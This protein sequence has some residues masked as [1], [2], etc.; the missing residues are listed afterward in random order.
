MTPRRTPA[1]ALVEALAQRTPVDDSIVA[2]LPEIADSDAWLL[3]A[4]IGKALPTEVEVRRAARLARR[5]G[6]A[7]LIEFC[8]REARRGGRTARRVRLLRDAVVVDVRHTA[9]TELA[10]GIQ[11]VARETVRR[12]HHDHDVTLA[13]WTEDSMSLRVLQPAEE[14][15]ALHGVFPEHRTSAAIDRDV[16]VPVGGVFLL[17]ELAAESWRTDRIAALARHSGAVS[18]VIGFD[19]V[20]LTTA[21]TVGAGMSGAFARNLNAVAEMD[22]VVAISEAAAAEYRGWRAML[23]SKGLVGPDIHAVLLAADRRDSTAEEIAYFR[24]LVGNEEDEPIVFVVGSHEPRKNHGAVIH[25]AELLWNEGERF[26]LVFVGGNAWNSHD[27]T[28]RVKRLQAE[29]RPVVTLH[30]IAEPVL[31]AG[32]HVARFTVFPSLNEGYGLPIAESAACG[33]PVVTSAYGSMREVG[34]GNGALLVDPHDD[35]SVAEGIRTLLRD[36]ATFARLSAEAEAYRP[37]SW[38]EYAAL[39]WQYLVHGGR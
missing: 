29:G 2:A 14:A 4:A 10:T 22:R 15:T 20:P 37:R 30:S 16:I 6:V 12:W 11:R 33:T 36:D 23:P 19:C 26:R 9:E 38:D 21:E 7:A 28:D 24:E 39:A 25:A 27:F 18:G 1:T 5:E 35:R 32:Y 13:T 31:W 8:R 34:E 3:L 17:P